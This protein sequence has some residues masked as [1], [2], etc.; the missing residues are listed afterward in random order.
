MGMLCVA[1]ANDFAGLS[2]IRVIRGIFSVP[3][4]YMAA[5]ILVAISVGA[6]MLGATLIGLLPIPFVGTLLQQTVSCYFLFVAARILG[7]LYYKSGP[8]LD[9]LAG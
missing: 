3:G 8:Q 2:P 7:L 1:L 9:W 5:W 4:R 6:Q